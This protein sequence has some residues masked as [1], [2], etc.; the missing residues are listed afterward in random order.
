[1]AAGGNLNPG[2]WLLLMLFP[3]PQ[4][5]TVS[6]FRMTPKKK[7]FKSL[8]EELFFKEANPNHDHD[9]QQ[10]YLTFSKQSV[11]T[12]LGQQDVLQVKIAL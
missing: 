2:S 1:M 9:V 3:P 12:L 8:A 10:L 11:V 5:R 4:L 6:A 7:T